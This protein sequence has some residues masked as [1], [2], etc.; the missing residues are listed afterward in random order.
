[1]AT[2]EISR[3]HTKDVE[4]VKADVREL[5]R[6]LCGRYGLSH[7]AHGDTMRVT[8]RGAEGRVVVRGTRVDVV[9]D[10]PFLLRPFRGTIE[11]AIRQELD[12]RLG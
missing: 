9:V 2:I 4:G 3:V 8:G 10:L 12:A 7:S 6:G 11:R 1:M 5:A